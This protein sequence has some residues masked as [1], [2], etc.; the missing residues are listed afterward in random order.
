MSD[1][2]TPVD[3]IVAVYVPIA[4]TFELLRRCVA[5]VLARTSHP[6]RLVLIDDCSPF[7]GV[8]DYLE[9]VRAANPGRDILVLSNPRNQGFIRT[10]N[11]AMAL[12]DADGRD[13]V[14]LNND[15]EVTTGWLGRLVRCARS[16]ERIATV[17]PFSNN[18]TIA[19]IPKMHQD[20]P[21]PPGLSVEDVARIV[22]ARS[23]GTVPELPSG[24]GF[25]LYIKRKALREVGA[26]DVENFGTGYGEENDLCCRLAARGYTHALDDSTFVFHRGEASYQGKRGDVTDAHFRKL[27]ALHPYIRDAVVEFET[28]DPLWRERAAL[29]EALAAGVV[30]DVDLELD[31][32]PRRP[33]VLMVGA[34]GGRHNGMARY[35]EDL[36]SALVDGYRV[37]LLDSDGSVLTLRDAGREEPWT[38]NLPERLT[39]NRLAGNHA[40]RAIIEHWLDVTGAELVHV[41]T[42]EG[43]TFDLVAAAHARSLPVLYA[44][45]DFHLVC[46]SKFLL[47]KEGSG[48]RDCLEGGAVGS[49]LAENPFL[50][51]GT[52]TPPWLAALRRDVAANVAPR[53]DAL[54]APSESAAATFT[55][56]YP[57]VAARMRVIPHGIRPQALPE[58]A[59]A[60][61]AR[62]HVALLGALHPIKGLDEARALVQAAPPGR[63]RFSHFGASGAAIPGVE[64]RGE[65]DA[66]QIG[67][68]LREAAVDLVLLPSKATETY[69]YTLSEALAAGLPVVA[70]D[71]GALAERVRSHGAGWVLDTRRT[72]AV[73]ELLLRLDAERGELER[74]RAR[75]GA[76]ALPSLPEMGAAYRALYSGLLAGRTRPVP[77]R[78]APPAQLFA[79]SRGRSSSDRTAALE[80]ALRD[81]RREVERL[82]HSLAVRMVRRLKGHPLLARLL[83]GARRPLH[84]LLR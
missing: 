7:P 81:A 8:L 56:T 20:N 63:L 18:A 27:V 4:D 47:T 45:H 46:P 59:P 12:G 29:G 72:P 39:W 70:N 2:P 36:C 84:R 14:L 55:R 62:L 83:E 80:A 32:P 3:V 61:D 68:L 53:F 49:C 17:T 71:A 77:E 16:H 82:E 1:A 6:H 25:C 11:R 26:F 21:L 5:S 40:Y 22:L 23:S 19:S 37:F 43:H 31:R 38:A 24:H 69:S 60:P 15:T 57:G 65:Y 74:V 44:V 51:P 64:A 50:A 33:A 67:R 10:A 75:V 78:V 30:P 79:A 52:P 54:V 35:T 73:L 66:R 28:Q 13:V 48:C 34:K 9:S 76:L 41:N 42:L 58:R